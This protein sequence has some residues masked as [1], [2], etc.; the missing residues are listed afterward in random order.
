MFKVAK[1]KSLRIFV[2]SVRRAHWASRLGVASLKHPPIFGLRTVFPQGGL[3]PCVQVIMWLSHAF[4]LGHVTMIQVVIARVYPLIY[5]EKMFDGSK[6]FRNQ[7]ME[8]KTSGKS[9]E[10]RKLKIEALC[11][12][13]EREF[14]NEVSRNG[15]FG[16]VIVWFYCFCLHLS[17]AQMAK[18]RR[19]SGRLTSRS[20]RNL[21]DGED[22][23]NT[24]KSVDDPDTLMVSNKG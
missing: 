1:G 19:R 12:K 21:Q 14:E 4:S 2:N 16:I 18:R 15:W 20:L 9:N 17:E 24:V 22:I 6:V 10:V 23:Y 5:M 8:E 3:I 7:R 13:V 11:Q